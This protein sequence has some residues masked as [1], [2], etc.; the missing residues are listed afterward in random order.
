MPLPCH[1][2][3]GASGKDDH[4]EADGNQNFEEIE[5]GWEEKGVKKDGIEKSKPWSANDEGE[6]GLIVMQ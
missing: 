6:D 3:V 1:G 4:T 5:P 2:K